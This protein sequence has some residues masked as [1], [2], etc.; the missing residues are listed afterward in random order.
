MRAT[1]PKSA[2]L[3]HEREIRAVM[4]SGRSR[5]GDL[6]RLLVHPNGL[7]RARLGIVVSRRLGG[8]VAR[9]RWKRLLRE[10]FRLRRHAL[11]AWD[12]VAIPLRPPGRLRR[13]DVDGEFEALV[14]ALAG[15]E[16]VPCG[17]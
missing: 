8:A 17:G 7:G 6:L 5:S 10:T 2:R 1:F 14:R 3:R 16:D 15:E 4:R 11:P 13:P 12:I 9:N